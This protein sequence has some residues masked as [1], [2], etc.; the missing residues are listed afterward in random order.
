MAKWTAFLLQE[1]NRNNV[2]YQKALAD[3]KQNPN[4]DGAFVVETVVVPDSVVNTTL[5]EDVEL[6][7]HVE[8]PMDAEVRAFPLSKQP[9]FC[10]SVDLGYTAYRAKHTSMTTNEATLRCC[11]EIIPCIDHLHRQ[12]YEILQ[13]G[14]HAR[15]PAHLE[16][17]QFQVMGSVPV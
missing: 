8:V 3:G 6:L 5:F 10:T 4:P 17:E 13:G 15:Q 16:Y 7:G 14:S 12:T 11:L 2:E 1:I 9:R